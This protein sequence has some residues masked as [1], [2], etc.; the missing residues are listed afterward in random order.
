MPVADSTSLSIDAQ[1]AEGSD[2]RPGSKAQAGKVPSLGNAR[3]E[4]VAQAVLLVF[5]LAS[6]ALMSVHTNQMSDNDIWW[7]LRTG[8]WIAAHHAVPHVELFSRSAAGVPWVAYSWLFELPV[9]LLFRSLGLVGLVSY[10]AAFVLLITMALYRMVQRERAQLPAAALLTFASMYAMG[11]MY[12]PRP[13]MFTIVLF[14]CELSILMRVRNTGQLRPLFWLPA[15]FA[16]WANAHIQFVY[17]LFVLGL[18]A[19]E[20]LSSRWWAGA[21]KKI[22]AAPLLVAFAASAA[23]TLINP[24][25]WRVYAVAHDFASQTGALNLISELQAL[26]FRD[27]PAYIVLFLALACAAFL[28]QQRRLISFEG[29]LF[30][31]AALLSFRSQR[32]VW[33]MAVVA[34]A[35]LAPAL[36]KVRLSFQQPSG[37]TTLFAMGAAALILPVGCRLLGTNRTSLNSQLAEHMPVAAAE[38]I[39]HNHYPGPV[40]NDF[41]WG[42]YL[43]W[44]LRM[45]VTIDG[46]QNVY[47]DQRMNRSVVT[48]SGQPDWAADPDLVS[49]RL[50]IGPTHSPLTQ[51]LRTDTRFRLAYEDK[52][53]AVFVAQDGAASV[54]DSL[55]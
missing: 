31:L 49:A 44:S 48:W 23:A 40:F 25:G 26:S 14:T 32:D 7:H 29:G 55:F 9:F 16:V 34:A 28:G 22:G 52:L 42:G 46:R 45:P 33:M 50:V 20:A 19:A 24:Y 5:L 12:T 37:G 17:G 4:R 10:T 35:I 11:P 43:I 47:G 6:P 15:I 21:Q 51:L 1:P 41:N 54:S 39:T 2:S 3:A 13:W 30:A 8:E 27:L 38:N 18:A 36:P 53:A